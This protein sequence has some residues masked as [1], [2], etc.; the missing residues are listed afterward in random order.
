MRA[1]CHAAFP[2]AKAEGRLP[3]IEEITAPQVRMPY[4]DACMQEIVRHARPL[5]LMQRETVVETELLGVRIP[6][7]VNIGFTSNGPGYMSAP[8]HVDEEKRHE[9]ARASRDRTGA[10]EPATLGTFWPERWITTTDDGE[11]EFDA[12]TAPFLSF[13]EGPRMCFGKKLALLEMRIFYILVLWHFELRPVPPA[14]ETEEE[15]LFLTRI[16][17]HAWLRLENIRYE[18][19]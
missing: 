8:L 13:G 5:A 6:R 14:C 1:T 19:A 4:I 15:A 17:K 12:R 10:P 9:T 2:E 11:E 3:T 16:P 18:K 7:G